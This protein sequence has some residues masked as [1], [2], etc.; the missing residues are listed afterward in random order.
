MPWNRG[1]LRRK[2]QASTFQ[3]NLQEWQYLSDLLQSG[4]PLLDALS[5]LHKQEL[6]LKERLEEG[7][8]LLA[9]LSEHKK[10][11]FYDHLRF[12]MKITSLPDAINCSLHMLSFESGLRKNLIKKSVYPLFIFVF[13]YVMLLVFTTWIIPQMLTSFDQDESFSS[14]L[15]MIYLI[16][17]LCSLLA[18][19]VIFSVVTAWY[20]RLHATVRIHLMKKAASRIHILRDYV[21]YMFSGYLL[22]LEQQG[23]STRRAMHYLQQIAGT[24]LFSSF[25]KDVAHDL[26]EGIALPDIM[27]ESKLLSEGFQLSF[28]IGASTSSLTRLLTAF[29]KQQEHLWEQTIQKASIIL[30]CVAYSF[31]GIVV[32]IV[33]QIMMVPLSMLETM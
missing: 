29:M 15:M 4:Y 17:G 13:A 31:V 25:I 23:I 9:I 27:E 24:T 2:K 11:R 1:R 21:S 16:K 19:S 28:R 18:V 20:L 33:Y 8:D 22:E 7:E 10:G 14:L 3:L 6:R 5:F 32:L 26:E 30:Q 12:F